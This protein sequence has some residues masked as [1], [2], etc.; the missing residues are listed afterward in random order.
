MF[1]YD[2]AMTDSP[3]M[4]ANGKPDQSRNRM[5]SQCHDY[6]GFVSK[7]KIISVVVRRLSMG[8]SGL[9]YLAALCMLQKVCKMQSGLSMAAGLRFVALIFES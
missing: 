3:S 6:P 4:L 2:P 7:I 9:L 8:K 1:Y 5:C